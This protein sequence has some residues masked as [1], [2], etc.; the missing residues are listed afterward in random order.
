MDGEKGFCSKI[1][2]TNIYREAMSQLKD[3]LEN[4]ECH[5]LD[6]YNMRAQRDEC[7]LRDKDALDKAI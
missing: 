2:G 3:V 7:G 4:S 6:R 1:I 5:T